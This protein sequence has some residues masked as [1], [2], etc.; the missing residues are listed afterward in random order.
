V[1]FD[2][3]EN[4]VEFPSLEDRLEPEKAQQAGGPAGGLTGMV[5]GWIWG[6]GSKK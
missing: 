2:L 5:K 1:L 3:A 4:Y 6:G